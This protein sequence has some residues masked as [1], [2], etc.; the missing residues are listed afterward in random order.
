MI[1]DHLR[2]LRLKFL[3]FLPQFLAQRGDVLLDLPVRLTRPVG[4]D[5][6]RGAPNKTFITG[7]TIGMV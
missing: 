4:E 6:I 7:T 2:F 3:C 5:L 1:R